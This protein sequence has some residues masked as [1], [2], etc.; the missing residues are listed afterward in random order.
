MLCVI[1]DCA[2]CARGVQLSRSFRNARYRRRPSVWGEW[3]PATRSSTHPHPR[4][5]RLRPHAAPTHTHTTTT[6]TNIAGWF[7]YRN[8]PTPTHTRTPGEA[9]L[10]LYARA[11]PQNTNTPGQVRCCHRRA[12][13]GCAPRRA[14][15]GGVGRPRA[16]RRTCI[17]PSSILLW[18]APPAWRVSVQ[19]GGSAAGPRIIHRCRPRAL[20]LFSRAA[21]VTSYGSQ[22]G[23]SSFAFSESQ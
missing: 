2:G 3:A 17:A 9:P 1:C 21:T 13:T 8:T 23:R 5:T 20:Y 15:V 10:Y 18:H 16:A 19:V 4:P 14:R 11:P 6:T 12:I 7:A 22:L